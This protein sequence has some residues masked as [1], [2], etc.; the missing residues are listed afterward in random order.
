[1]KFVN[2]N[3]LC[4]EDADATHAGLSIAAIRKAKQRNSPSWKFHEHPEDKRKILFEYEKLKEDDKKKVIARFGNPYE[5][6]AKMP[7]RNLVK[8]DDKAEEFYLAYRF[9]GNKTLPVEHVKKYTTAAS[10]L[11]MFKEVTQDKK[12]LKKLLNLTIEQ[13]FTN[14]IEIIIANKIDLPTSYLRLIGRSDS[15]LKKY[16][17]EGYTSLIDWRFGNKLA[18]KIKDEVSESML[19]DMLSKGN[20]HD[21]VVIRIQYN[22]WAAEN[23][24]KQIDEAT[25]G[26]WRRK[27][28]ADLEMER[29]GNASLKNKYLRQAK[30]FRPSQPLYLVE[31]DDNHLDLAFLDSDNENSSPRYIVYVVSDSYND[32]PLGYAYAL[33]G[34]LHEGQSIALVKAAYANAMYYLRSITGQWILPHET[35]TDNWA[36]KSLKPFY[37]SL[38]NYIETPVGSKNRGYIENKFGT[39]YHWKRCLKLVSEKH[40]NYLGNNMTA[41]FRGVNTEMVARRKKDRPLIGT[42][43]HQ[44]IE[45][46]FHLLRHLPQSND[47]SKHDQWMQAF[48]ALPAE[49]KRIITDEQFLL[50]FGIEHNENG[51]TIRIT[52]RGVE[53]QING[54]KYSFDL[55]GGS[56]MEHVGKA[57]KVVYDPFDMS[58]VLI[59]NYQ[60]LR[61]IGREARLNPRALK[62]SHTD[63]R[64][65]LNSILLE[66]K[67]DVE[68]IAAK[69]ERRRQVL[70]S[71]GFDAESVLQSGVL[72]KEIKQAAEQAMTAKMI[73][74]PTGDNYFEQM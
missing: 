18:A 65:Y 4:L 70:L 15:A 46:F 23:N 38:G 28:A 50:K 73:D 19:L 40:G 14:A 72:V 69:S 62:D 29:E 2:G 55:E 27:H 10:W 5:Y 64:K 17:S 54:V 21:D 7:I 67:Q 24:Y 1:M 61:I 74:G 3:I 53:P 47:I 39:K 60:D 9:D 52:N 26:V 32:Y 45:T 6:M 42:E 35:K 37:Q 34:T 44:Q 11:N 41:K 12:Q 8:W 22:K 56:W 13:F 66:K 58:R 20:Q 71:A 51:R 30:G 57:V 63:S 49:E 59:T 25:V 43:A 16:I 33:A 48:N 31:S 68:R 36:I